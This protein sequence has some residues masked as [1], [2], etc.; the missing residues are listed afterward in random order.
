MRWRSALAKS[1]CLVCG[2]RYG[3]YLLILYLVV[4]FL[5]VFNAVSQVF[6]LN[7][8]LRTDYHVYGLE[9]MR[10][11]YNP[12]ITYSPRFPR[13]TLCD[14]LIRQLANTHRHTVQCVLPINLFNEKIFI[15]IWFWLV[16][17]SIVSAYNFLAWCLRAMCW[18]G[19][20]YF[21]KRH[22]RH[23]LPDEQDQD[24]VKKWVRGF[25]QDYLRH[26]GLLVLRLLEMNTNHLVTA[27]LIRDLWNEYKVKRPKLDRNPS[28]ESLVEV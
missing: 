16:F 13:V 15:F 18:R 2:R 7:M 11:I 4:K 10:N 12:D 26:D 14:F 28:H 3:N 1:A 24:E 27:E 20:Q 8:F 25:V 9:V 19:Q 17:M 6:L 21:V 23:M 5:F 22:L